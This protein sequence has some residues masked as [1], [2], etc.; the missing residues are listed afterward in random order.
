MAGNEEPLNYSPIRRAAA[1]PFAI[2]FG[3]PSRWVLHA[4]GVEG[5]LGFFAI[6][7]R[8][9][10]G[11]LARA[12]RC[13]KAPQMALALPSWRGLKALGAFTCGWEVRHGAETYRR[14]GGSGL[15][16]GVRASR[17]YMQP[18][19]SRCPWSAASGQD[20]GGC[21][22]LG[23][24][25]HRPQAA[26]SSSAATAVGVLPATGFAPK[27]RALRPACLFAFGVPA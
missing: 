18:V 11:C 9:I 6:L 13:S 7:G 16:A 26:C 27:L 5:V 2:P 24:S 20:A 1:H 10:H 17:A 15:P 21:E 19:P 12:R 22:G 3:A 8:R 23:Q 25:P 4:A 14:G